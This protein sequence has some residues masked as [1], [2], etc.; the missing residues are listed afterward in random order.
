V[1]VAGGTAHPNRCQVDTLDLLERRVLR[2]SLRV[3][4]GLQQRVALDWQR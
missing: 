4:R 1:Q 3:A 2:E